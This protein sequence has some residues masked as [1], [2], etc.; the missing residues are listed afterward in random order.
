[1]SHITRTAP[2]ACFLTKYLHRGIYPIMTNECNVVTIIVF[3]SFENESAKEVKT[4]SEYVHST[5]E[6]AKATQGKITCQIP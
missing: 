2:S 6:H 1:M 3:S 4:S 5:I